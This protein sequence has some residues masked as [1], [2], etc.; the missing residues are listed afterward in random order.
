MENNETRVNYTGSIYSIYHIFA[1]VYAF[2]YWGFGWGILN[3]FI[4]Y[5]PLYD[6]VIYLGRIK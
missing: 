1:V 3:L 5:A 4:P 2:I 6:L